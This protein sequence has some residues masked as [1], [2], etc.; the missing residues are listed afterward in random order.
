[1][2]K[3]RVDKNRS[4]KWPASKVCLDLC[5]SSR[6]QHH[7]PQFREFVNE[8]LYKHNT[9]R[10]SQ[11]IQTWETFI[12]LFIF[13]RGTFKNMY[14]LPKSNRNQR[15]LIHI[16]GLQ[17]SYWYA[18]LMFRFRI[19]GHFVSFDTP[20]LAMH[21]DYWE[22]ANACKLTELIKARQHLT[23]PCVTVEHP[24]PACS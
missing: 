12:Y 8:V 2:Q 1:M 7:L 13:G 11:G 15:N 19:H 23:H 4:N 6:P 20:K 3:P 17:M 10:L 24:R 22:I 18:I 5:S 9:N 21:M 14:W 16:W